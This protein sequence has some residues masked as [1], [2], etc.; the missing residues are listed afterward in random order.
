MSSI[1]NLPVVIDHRIGA[2]SRL[3]FRESIRL[4]ETDP[5]TPDTHDCCPNREHRSANYL[6]TC[7]SSLRRAGKSY[8]RMQL[9]RLADTSRPCN[10]QPGA[11]WRKMRGAGQ[12]RARTW[13][14]DAGFDV[15]R[16][17]MVL[18]DSRESFE[19]CRRRQTFWPR[20]RGD[21]LLGQFRADQVR[22]WRTA[23]TRRGCPGPRHEAGRAVR[24][25]ARAGQ[26][27]R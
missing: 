16:V 5:A 1:E 8:K 17:S 4:R 12:T 22:S 6:P 10:R 26:R 7:E 3:R 20:R 24:R 9:A 27:S 15:S 21:G 2:S 18:N 14:P 11:H 13:R 23:R 25:S 19:K